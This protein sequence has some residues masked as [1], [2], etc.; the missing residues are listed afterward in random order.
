MSDTPAAPD[1]GNGESD[2]RPNAGKAG[3]GRASR[4]K[5]DAIW[6]H[7]LLRLVNPDRWSLRGRFVYASGVLL[8][9]GVITTIFFVS[10]ALNRGLD[11]ALADRLDTYER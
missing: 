2:P 6:R 4:D 10:H 11:A 9:L 1:H 7:R 8:L 5:G 3:R